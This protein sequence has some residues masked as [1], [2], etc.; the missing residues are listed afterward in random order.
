MKRHANASLIFATLNPGP[1]D[2]DAI[3]LLLL[4]PVAWR[5]MSWLA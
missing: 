5:G 3:V 4:L 1:V 2:G